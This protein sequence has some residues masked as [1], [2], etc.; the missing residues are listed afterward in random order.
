M[1]RNS[2]IYVSHKVS[3]L[4]RHI[5]KSMNGDAPSADS[6]MTPDK[7]ADDILIQWVK[8]NRPKLLELYSRR[9]ALEVEAQELLKGKP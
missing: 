8:Q 9:E 5:V 7:L 2:E 4:L 6:H 1:T 3:W